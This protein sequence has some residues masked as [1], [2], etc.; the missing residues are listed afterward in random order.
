MVGLIVPGGWEEFFR[1]VG[2]PYSGPHWP[3][4]DKRN[5]FEVLIPK[6]KAAAEKFDM[7]PLPQ[8]KQF[9]P[10]AWEDND[11]TLPGKLEPYFLKAGSGPAWLAGGSVVRPLITTAES[12][13]KFAIGSIEGTSHHASAE[14]FSEGRRVTFPQ[15]HHAFQVSEGAV[16]FTL[17]DSPPTRLHAG[18]IIYVPRS[19]TFHYQIRSRYAKFYAFASGKGIV[20]LLAG[21]GEKYESPIPPEKVEK[22]VNGEKLKTSG[23]KVGCEIC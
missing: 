11:S 16:E 15:T 19:T 6:L 5:I 4:D 1:F 12:G 23:K 3:M 10:S 18:E 17:G 8:H 21:V 20:E 9:P 13:G 7:I 14:I 2:E 22:H